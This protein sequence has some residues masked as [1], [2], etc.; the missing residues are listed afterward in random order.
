MGKAL[1]FGVN[2][3]WLC[4]KLETNVV[5]NITVNLPFV[6]RIHFI[7][8]WNNTH[9]LFRIVLL[10]LLMILDALKEYL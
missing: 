6:I 5:K 1:I 2:K 7:Q 10:T 8:L 4:T 9:F 3:A